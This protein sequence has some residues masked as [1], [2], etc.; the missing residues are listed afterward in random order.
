V[1]TGDFV[2]TET[3]RRIGIGS[4][5]PAAYSSPTPRLLP[6]RGNHDGSP[7]RFRRFLAFPRTTP[8]PVDVTLAVLDSGDESWG[9]LPAQARWLEGSWPPAA[10]SGSGHPLSPLF[11]REKHFGGWE[12]LRE[13]FAP[14][15]SRQGVRAVFQGHVH[16]YERDSTGGCSSDRRPRR[17]SAVPAR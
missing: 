13:T 12:N 5:V 16:L 3:G 15:F 2:L 7:D 8:S 9:D 4:S 10:P 17:G 14:V 6:V 1:H 11:V